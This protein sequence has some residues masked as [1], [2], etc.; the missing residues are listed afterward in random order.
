MLFTFLSTTF[1][2]SVGSSCA[3]KIF[4]GHEDGMAAESHPGIREDEFLAP[5]TLL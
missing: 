4:N 2:I 3:T 5:L 1:A